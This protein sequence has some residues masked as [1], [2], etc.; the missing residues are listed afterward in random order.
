M[1]AT[2]RRL[3]ERAPDSW[4]ALATV[5]ALLLDREGP[6]PARPYLLEAWIRNPASRAVSYRLSHVYA[7]LARPEP[8]LAFL[9]RAIDNGLPRATIAADP[10]LQSLRDHAIFQTLLAE[11][12]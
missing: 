10:V 6:Q 8:A 11:T 2:A 5:G 3:L 1:L 9:G 7:R 4:R 12:P